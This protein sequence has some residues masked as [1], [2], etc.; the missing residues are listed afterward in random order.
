MKFS[1]LG[2]FEARRGKVSLVFD[3]MYLNLQQGIPVP[4]NGAYSGGSSRVKTTEASAI[5]LYTLLDQ[6]GGRFELGGGLRA[7][8]LN[9]EINLDP[10]LLP[11]RFAD[12]TTNWVDPVIAAA[13]PCA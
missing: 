11:G 10:G 3:L 8:W 2:I 13:P 12:A 9:T 6:P 5:G 4:G 7:W 1:C